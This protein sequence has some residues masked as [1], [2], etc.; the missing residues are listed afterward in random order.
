MRVIKF[1]GKRT[2]NG[3]WIY[4]SLVVLNSQYEICDSSSFSNM[5][6]EVEEE[7]VGQFTG[8]TDKKYNPIYEGDLVKCDHFEPSVY[9]VEFIEGAFCLA[10]PE[11]GIP[12]DVTHMEDSKGK[13][14]EVIGNFTDNPE[15]L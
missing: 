2:D 3:E 10:N 11:V 12:M 9:H 14:F 15:L 5:R 8:L 7:T 13:H 4:G 1:R 6:Y